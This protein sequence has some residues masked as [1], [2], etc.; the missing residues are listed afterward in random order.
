MTSDNNEINMAIAIFRGY[1]AILVGGW[2][3]TP[4]H[5]AVVD[6]SGRHTS[7][8][9]QTPEEA[10]KALWGRYENECNWAT[11]LDRCKDLMAEVIAA[12]HDKEDR[13]TWSIDYD[14]YLQGQWKAR[15]THWSYDG[16]AHGFWDGVASTI[17]LAICLAYIEWKQRI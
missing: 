16:E 2:K 8:M 12:S 7:G 13:F 10:W 14:E 3:A 5:Y 11:N 15:V 1:K 4:G 6:P 9:R 17:E